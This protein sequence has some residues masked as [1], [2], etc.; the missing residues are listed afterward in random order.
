[1]PTRL[2]KY[3]GADF[4]R[5]MSMVYVFGND[6]DQEF[7]PELFRPAY[8]VAV[9]PAVVVFGRSCAAASAAASAVDCSFRFA[10]YQEPKS[11][12]M[13]PIAIRPVNMRTTMT[14]TL[15]RSLR[16]RFIPFAPWSCWSTCPT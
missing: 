7:S 8:D 13:P 16:S 10:V 12:V 15:P 5:L 9:C 1:M 2:E 3:D 11:S 6:G 14:R 4:D